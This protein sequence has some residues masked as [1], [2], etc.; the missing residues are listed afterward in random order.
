VLGYTHVSGDRDEGYDY[1]TLTIAGGEISSDTFVRVRDRIVRSAADRRTF[2]IKT[3][4]GGDGYAASQSVS[5]S[6]GTN[7]TSRSSAFARPR[8]R[9]GSSLQGEPN[10]KEGEWHPERHPAYAEVY[11]ATYP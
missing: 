8:A 6:T 5:S 2:I 11:E 1:E 3:S 10:M 9:T 4:P 7:G